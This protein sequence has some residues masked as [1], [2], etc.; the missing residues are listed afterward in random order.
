VP[1]TGD[2]AVAKKSTQGNIADFGLEGVAVVAVLLIK[3]CT[4]G[5]GTKTAVRRAAVTATTRPWFH[6][7][8]QSC[9]AAARLSNPSWPLSL[10]ASGTAPSG[11]RRE[12]RRL[13]ALRA[14]RPC[15]PNCE[16]ESRP[17]GSPALNGSIT[18]PK[19]AT[20]AIS[21]CSIS[22][23]LFTGPARGSVFFGPLKIDTLVA[24]V[25]PPDGKPMKIT[26]CQRN[27]LVE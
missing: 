9:N 6:S 21:V 15:R 26:R 2:F 4:R 3:G 25:L 20:I 17:F 22:F 5:P 23:T 18:I 12:A 8:V 13:P 11:L 1:P 14:P 16:S 10:H 19:K 27:I 24:Q 7:S